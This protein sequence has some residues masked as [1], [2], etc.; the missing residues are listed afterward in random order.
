MTVHVHARQTEH[1]VNCMVVYACVHVCVCVCVC[2]CVFVHVHACICQTGS[3]VI[4]SY[5]KSCVKDLTHV[6]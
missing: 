3:S 1:P 6:C 2:V 4:L 5:L